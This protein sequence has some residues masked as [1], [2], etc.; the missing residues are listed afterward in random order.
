MRSSGRLVVLSS[1]VLSL[2][3]SPAACGGGGPAAPDVVTADQAGPPPDAGRLDGGEGPDTAAPGTPWRVGAAEAVVTPP[4]P[5]ILGGYG[6]CGGGL[7]NCRWSEGVHDDLRAAAVAFE[8]AHTGA[9]VVFVGVD[10]LGLMMGDVLAIQAAFAERVAAASGRVIPADRVIVSSSHSHAA[11]DSVGIWGSMPDATGRDP[12][13]AAFVV[14]RVA[15][16][17]AAAVADLGDAD[18]VVARGWHDNAPDVE[19]EVA[20]MAMDGRLTVLRATRPDGTPVATLTSWPSHPTVYPEGNSAVSADWVGPFRHRLADRLGPG[21]VQAYLQGPIGGVYAV[22]PGASPGA[23]ADCAEPN[24]LTAGW[25]DPD[26]TALDHD[27]V[28]CVG[29]AVADAA[30]ALLEDAVPLAAGPLTVASAPLGVPVLNAIYGILAAQGMLDREIPPAADPEGAPS[31]MTLVRLGALR[32]V[33]VPGEAFPEYAAALRARIAERDAVATDDVV[34]VGLGNDW[35][36]YLLL[37]EQYADRAYAYHRGLSP[38]PGCLAAQ[39]G[40][41]DGLL[42]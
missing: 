39:L 29:F 9:V 16:A 13:Y 11:P 23:P 6:F 32:F 38:G 7:E 18:V 4:S 41:L 2:A 15:Q 8:A 21:G 42:D 22:T 12:D 5:Q 14:D 27:R 34:V 31:L 36:G 26:L 33:T 37:P 20:P 19:S 24:P 35:V 1:V 17:A 3:L 40:A 10:S 28:A 30:L 25:Q